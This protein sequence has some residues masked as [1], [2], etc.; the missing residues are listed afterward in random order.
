MACENRLMDS[1]GK[2]TGLSNS[3]EYWWICNLS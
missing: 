2:K 1:N 3:I